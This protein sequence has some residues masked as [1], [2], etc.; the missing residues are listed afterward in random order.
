LAT[1][2]DEPEAASS[3]SMATTARRARKRDTTRLPRRSQA[4]AGIRPIAH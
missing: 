1:I 3:K 4:Y 2:C